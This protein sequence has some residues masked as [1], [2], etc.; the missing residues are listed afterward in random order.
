M[1]AMSGNRVVMREVF[2][3]DSFCQRSCNQLRRFFV[4]LRGVFFWGFFPRWVGL[5]W[6]FEPLVQRFVLRRIRRLA[7][8]RDVT[9]AIK[10]GCKAMV[11]RNSWTLRFRALRRAKE[12]YDFRIRMKYWNELERNIVFE[13]LFIKPVEIGK[14]ALFSLQID[15]DRPSLGFDSP[16]FPDTL[17]TK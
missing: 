2:I 4:W 12:H 16:D 10:Y 17:P 6:F 5:F 1:T 7:L 14:I 9:E 13:K 3:W 8:Y 11:L 15:N